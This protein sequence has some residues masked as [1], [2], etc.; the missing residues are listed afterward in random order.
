MLDFFERAIAFK[1]SVYAVTYDVSADN[2]QRVGIELK[3]EGIDPIPLPLYRLGKNKALFLDRDGIINKDLGYVHKSEDV[4]FQEGIFDLV[5]WAMK[6]S[7]L[8][9]VLTNQSGI[10]K[11]YYGID[12][13]KKLHQFMDAEFARRKLKITAWYHCPFHNESLLRKPHPGMAL[14][15]SYEWDLDISRSIMIGDKKTDRLQGLNL[16]TLFLKEKH[17]LSGEENIFTSLQAILSF[18]KGEQKNA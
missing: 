1:K 18:L 3:F 16:K 6:N 11:G 8:V 9:I 2:Y 7:Y 15:A 12:D 13:V 5:S 4:I 10:A 17:D 14:K